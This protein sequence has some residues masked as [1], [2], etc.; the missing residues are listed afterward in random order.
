MK[1]LKAT[2]RRNKASLVV[3]AMFIIAIVTFLFALNGFIA[4]IDATT[5]GADL[6]LSTAF[7]VMSYGGGAAWAYLMTGFVLML[8]SFL[9]L[10]MIALNVK[11]DY[12][13][14]SGVFNT[15][16][17]LICVSVLNFV[18]LALVI[19]LPSMPVLW[20]AVLVTGAAVAACCLSA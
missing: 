9:P 11:L 6:D 4:E 18:G 14:G 12:A 5:A 8:C 17:L 2:L 16:A 10:G 15:L 1:E 3:E 13:S 20:A 7:A 19:S